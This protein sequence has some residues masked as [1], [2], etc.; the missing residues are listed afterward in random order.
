VS[1]VEKRIDEIADCEFV[2]KDIAGQFARYARLN[3]L[4][5]HDLARELANAE[6]AAQQAMRQ[7]KG[8]P[9]L[10]GIDVMLRARK[11]TRVF[12][13]AREVCEGISAEC[14]AFHVQFRQEYAEELRGKRNA[15]SKDYRGKVDL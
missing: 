11:V 15:K 8:H 7:L 3:Q 13:E 6:E 5:A 14:V 2:G 10:A 4:L 1:S 9:L 12:R